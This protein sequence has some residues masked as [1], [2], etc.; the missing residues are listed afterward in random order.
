MNINLSSLSLLKP[1]SVGMSSD[2][3]FSLDELLLRHVARGNI[4]GAVVA[5]SRQGKP[6][7]FAA[8]GVSD[9]GTNAPM[10]P[11]AMFQMASSTKGVLGVAAMIAMERGLISPDDEIQKFIPGFK[12][13][14]VAVLKNP[15]HK[16]VSPKL[17]LARPANKGPGLLFR[18]ISTLRAKYTN[19]YLHVPPHRIVPACHPITIHDLLT[20]TA[21]LG[22]YGLGAAVSEWAVWEKGGF[23]LK[24]DSLASYIEKVSAGPLDFQPGTRWMYS[25]SVGLDVVARVIEIAADKPINEFVQENIFDPLDMID[26]HWNVPPEKHHRVV[27]VKKDPGNWKQET[28]YFSGSSGLISTARDYLHFEQMLLDGGEFSGRRIL[29]ESS[30]QLMSTNQASDLY[31]QSDKGKSGGEGFGYTGVIT[32]LPEKAVI[33]KSV[34]AFGFQGAAGTTSWSEPARDLAVVIMVQQ[35]TTDLARDVSVVIRDA[36]LD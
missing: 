13:I 4:Q 23:H 15:A 2:K 19:T 28:S 17:I 33:P 7:Y 18:A 11:D 12:D 31:K 20:H 6:V 8:H 22:T 16:D 21:G 35:L 36:F 1:E 25:P 10:Q 30:V 26:T 29:E 32:Q 24:E 27:V 14:A 9:K 34:G 5:V 3:L